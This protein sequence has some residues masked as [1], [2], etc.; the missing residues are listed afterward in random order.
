MIT[1]FRRLIFTSSEL[2]KA[3]KAFSKEKVS[4]LPEGDVLGVEVVGTPDICARVRMGD[5]YGRTEEQEVVLDAIHLGATMLFHC[6]QNRI[7]M[8]R[9][10][11]KTLERVGDG[12]AL[13]FSINAASDSADLPGS[14]VTA[15]PGEWFQ[16]SDL[17][18]GQGEVILVLED[19][20]EVRS[21]AVSALTGAGYR[22]LEAGDAKA[23]AQVL[24]K[25]AE[26][27]DL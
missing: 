12:L 17:K 16:S 13:S 1:E 7:P 14:D 20:P 19:D 27:L 25:E 22:V 11:K 6:K 4:I 23:A 18:R 9:T 3:I 10:P 2:E 15:G 21:L 26:N 8:P 5:A 24:E